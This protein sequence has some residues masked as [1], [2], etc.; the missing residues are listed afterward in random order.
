[1]PPLGDGHEITRRDVIKGT[2]GS[3]G[4]GLIAGCSGDGGSGGDGGSSGD[5]GGQS[6]DGSS[7]GNGE[8]PELTVWSFGPHAW[9]A[10]ALAEQYDKANVTVES[11]PGGK[12][13]QQLTQSVQAGANVPDLSVVRKR[14]NQQYQKQQQLVEINDIVEKY[15]EDMFTVAKTATKWSDEWRI[16]VQDAGPAAMYYNV[17]VFEEA[18]L[19]TDPDEVESYI[20]TWEDYISAG[21]E[22][23]AATGTKLLNLPSSDQAGQLPHYI[24]KQTCGWWYNDKGEFQWDQQK[25]IDGYKIVEDLKDV[26]V[27]YKRQSPRTAEAFRNE[28]MATWP[29]AAWGKFWFQENLPEMSGK[30]RMCRLPRFKD[31]DRAANMGNSAM[32]IPVA[33][34]DEKKDIAKDFGEY[35]QFSDDAWETKLKEGL[36]PSID[37]PDHPMREQEDPYFGGQ[38]RIKMLIEIAQDCPIIYG[39]PN[40]R[41]FELFTDANT[42]IVQED[43]DPENV[44]PEINRQMEAEL[45]DENKTVPIDWREKYPDKCS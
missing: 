19:P 17:D 42:Q 15:E 23:E 44:I 4:A 7:G 33:I 12:I 27:T 14:I 36:F 22:I 35:M 6:S 34:P 13:N 26:S 37:K 39:A 30:W 43:K 20:E 45:S 5:G 31:G 32:G 3:I 29:I 28:E 1:M 40:F 38:K 41:V 11:K 9:Y 21:Q 18:G 2:G 16:F 25:N 24:C 10:E 8:K